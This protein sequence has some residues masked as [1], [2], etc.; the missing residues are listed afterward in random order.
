M[1]SLEQSLVNRAGTGMKIA[2]LMGSFNPIHNG[3][4]LLAQFVLEK[5]LFDAVWL[6]VT[7]A[8]PFKDSSTLAPYEHR[9]EM[10]RIAIKGAQ[11]IDVCTIE[12]ELTQP[13]YTYNT[14]TELNKRFPENQ[15]TILAGS[16][17]AHEIALWHKAEK[18]QTI[19]EFMYYPRTLGDCVCSDS[20]SE[21]PVLDVCSS[22]IRD[23][24]N[25]QHLNLG[26]IE[27]IYNHDLYPKA[28]DF[29]LFDILL[30][31]TPSA[32]L[33]YRRGKLF[34]GQGNFGE[35][36]NDFNAAL[37]LDHDHTA[38]QQMKTL[39][40]SVLEFRYTDLYNP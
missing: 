34:Y 2:L 35:A 4:I 38:S 6:M 15:F 32:E 14:I 28:L 11:G 9:V 30:A 39:A 5:K 37:K 36:I 25:L 18:L 19:V 21:A 23:G 26:V 7:P 20:L 10:A 27:Y 22:E 29:N 1:L 12:S 40:N 8:N 17:I 31:H 24:E 33:F 16:D 3:H 13:N